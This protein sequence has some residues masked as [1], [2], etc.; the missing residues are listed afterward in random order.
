MKSLHPGLLALALFASAAV[1]MGCEVDSAN[2]FS[3]D[4][5]VDFSGNYIGCDD[6]AIVYGISGSAINSLNLRQSGDSL[7][8]VDSNG[9]IWRGSLGEVQNNQSSFDLKGTTTEGVEAW[10]SGTIS[11]SGSEG[12]MSGTFIQADRYRPFCGVASGITIPSTNTSTNGS[13]TATN[14]NSTVSIDLPTGGLNKTPDAYAKIIRR[15]VE[16]EQ[17]DS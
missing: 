16:P 15:L 5:S 14:T 2:T 9:G 13:G 8:A 6:G 4:V 12:K 11:A 3:R 7:E 17:Q 10:F 1:Y